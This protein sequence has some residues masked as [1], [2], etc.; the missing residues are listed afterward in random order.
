MKINQGIVDLLLCYLLWGTFPFYFKLLGTV[1]ADQIV[2]HRIVWSFVLL[3]VVMGVRRELRDFRAIITGRN[4][5]IYLGAGLLLAA[6]WSLYVWGVTSGRVVESSLGYFINPLVSVL[7]GVIFLRES[8]RPMQWIPVVLAG[9][10]VLYLTISLGQFPWL[11]V[12]LA[13]TFGFY[14]LIKKTSPL[15]SLQGLSLETMTI[16]LP[17]L[18]YLIYS[19]I[20]GAGAFGHSSLL[21][22]FL[23]LLAGLVTVV[24]LLLFARGARKVPLTTLGLMQYTTP[25]LQ[26]LSGVLVFGEP[27]THQRL[28]GFSLVWLALIV[29]SLENLNARRLAVNPDV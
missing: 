13:L 23:L 27:F 18:G 11:S 1:P 14:G 2:A 25:T 6:N 24:P 20:S 3:L 4:F 5:L 28:I 21:I 29:F 12:L 19:E 7:L 16:F 17:A 15:G 26:F 9:G 10:G 22:N 8:L